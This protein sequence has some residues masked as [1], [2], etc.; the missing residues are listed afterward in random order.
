[1]ELKEQTFVGGDV[2]CDLLILHRSK[3]RVRIK[4]QPIGAATFSTSCRQLLN[5]FNTRA[6]KGAGHVLSWTTRGGSLRGEEKKEKTIKGVEEV[7]KFFPSL[8]SLKA[9]AKAILFYHWTSLFQEIIFKVKESRF[10]GGWNTPHLV[11]TYV[12]N[13][14][15]W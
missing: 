4:L 12:S 2:Q 10:S 11:W 7:N 5:S 1:M 3:E 9:F 6:L 15:N 14:K 8:V 13:F